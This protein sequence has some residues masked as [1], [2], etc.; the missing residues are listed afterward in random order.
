[1]S[2]VAVF[3]HRVVVAVH[4]VETGVGVGGA[5]IPEIGSDGGSRGIHKVCMVVIHA[6]IHYRNDDWAAIGDVVPS[7]FHSQ[8][9]SCA[10]IRSGDT[11]SCIIS[12]FAD[13]QSMR[14]PGWKRNSDIG[15]IV[16]GPLV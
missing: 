9:T 1:M 11:V 12:V 4:K 15:S 10:W 6:G 13:I 5:A 16:Q 3:V 14:R 2:S 7:G 8:I